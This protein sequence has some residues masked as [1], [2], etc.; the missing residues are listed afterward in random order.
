MEMQP[1]LIYSMCC[2]TRVAK[3]IFITTSVPDIAMEGGGREKIVYPYVDN[4]THVVSRDFRAI[5][6]EFRT[7]Q[8]KGYRRAAKRT[9]GITK[10]ITDAIFLAMK[11]L[12]TKQITRKLT[13]IS[14]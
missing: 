1:A 11:I 3:G 10:R 13:L 6:T 12:H 2:C 5:Y 7:K 9:M 8:K 4:Y 14:L